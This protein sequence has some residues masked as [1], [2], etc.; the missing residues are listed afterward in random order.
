M[1]VSMVSAAKAVIGSRRFW[2]VVAA[3]TALLWAVSM[4]PRGMV[5]SALS[6]MVGVLWGG[7]CLSVARAVVERCESL[8]SPV[9]EFRA[10]VRRGLSAIIVL[11]LPELAVYMLLVMLAL[12]V[13][14]GLGGAIELAQRIPHPHLGLLQRVWLPA[15]RLAAPFAIPVVVAAVDA[16]MVIVSGR[17]IA[18]DRLSEGFQYLDSWRQFVRHRVVGLRVIGW[19]LLGTAT[20]A[21]F[22]L[23]VLRSLGVD[24]F[25]G[26]PQVYAQLLLGLHW[27]WPGV[28]VLNFVVSGLSVLWGLIVARLLGLYAVTAFGVGRESDSV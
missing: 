9:V 24:P 21:V 2:P 26:Q 12:G 13:A 22:R 4:L 16:L 1:T 7:Y 25:R 14:F 18:F 27:P 8:P 5:Q 28:L 19:T 17:Y 11:A 20:L 23:L 6:S 10:I 15:P 3:G